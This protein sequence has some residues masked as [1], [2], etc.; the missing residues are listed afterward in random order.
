MA[1]GLISIKDF[2]EA[3]LGN[4]QNVRTLAD[5]GFPGGAGFESRYGQILQDS[6]LYVR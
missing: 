3:N 4:L 6:I 1:Y 5:S 2:F